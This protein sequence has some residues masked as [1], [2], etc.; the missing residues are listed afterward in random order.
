VPLSGGGS[1]VPANG[2]PQQR[3]I[4]IKKGDPVQLVA[5]DATFSVSRA[6]VADEDGAV[7]DM[8]RVRE[9]R[10]GTPVTG[11]VEPSGIVRIPGI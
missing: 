6:M 8:I 9:D 4:L 5:G 11:R 10:N 1:G 7:G 2:R 3:V